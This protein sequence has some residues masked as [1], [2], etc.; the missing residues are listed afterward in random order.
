MG[1]TCGG[2]LL[3]RSVPAVKLSPKYQVVIPPAI[4][5]AFKL[6]PGQ[7]IEVVVYDG[8]IT[9]APAI[10]ALERLVVPPPW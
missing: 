4:R 5:Q 7:K 2:P 9:L 8:R 1:L 6:K 10:E 3:E